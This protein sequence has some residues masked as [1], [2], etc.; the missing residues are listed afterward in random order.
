MI[1]RDEEQRLPDCLRSL[2][3]CDEIVVVID[4]RT[5]DRTEEIAR[6]FTDKVHRV[7][8]EGFGALFN[9]GLDRAAGDWIVFCDAEV[10][11]G[12][13]MLAATATLTYKVSSKPLTL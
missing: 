6:R 8:F 4:N 2:A 11:G 7:Q 5:A 9:A 13:G 3:F 1:A 12:S 10:R